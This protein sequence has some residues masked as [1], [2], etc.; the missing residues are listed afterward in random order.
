MGLIYKNNPRPLNPKPCFPVPGSV[1]RPRE[2]HFWVIWTDTDR[3][4]PS[5][6][7]NR[8][9]RTR[10][11]TVCNFG[12]PKIYTT[13]GLG[14]RKNREIAGVDDLVVYMQTAV[15]YSSLYIHHQM[16]HTS[17]FHICSRPKPGRC[18]C[19]QERII[20]VPGSGDCSIP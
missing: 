12:T 13:T 5:F 20:R 7:P 10:I 3:F 4:G 8:R 15:K 16:V 9:F 18:N 11:V 1:P 6:S 14:P 19:G 17:H 2:C